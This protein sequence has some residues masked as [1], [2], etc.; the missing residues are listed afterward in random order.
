MEKMIKVGDREVAFKATGDTPRLYRRAFTS[1]FFSDITALQTALTEFR[2]QSKPMP[3]QTLEIFEN[4]AYI[5][6]KQAD[7]NVPDT[8]DEWLDGFDMF[9]IYEILPQIVALWGVNMQTTSESK[10]KA[11]KPKG[12]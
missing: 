10:K 1:E 3:V 9:S 6:A 8:P 5:M 11:S 12:R 7:P 2:K 4:V